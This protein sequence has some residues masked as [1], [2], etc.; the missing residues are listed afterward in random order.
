[1]AFTAT[2][3]VRTTAALA[4]GLVLG[5]TAH[6]QDT[7]PSKPIKIVVPFPPGQQSDDMARVIAA[8]LK[9]AMGQPVIVEN[10][11]GQAGSIG[12]AQFA[13][14][15]P[16]GYTLLL[17]ATA[18]FSSNKFLYRNVPYDPLK[19]F[20]P[21]TMLSTTPLV[22]VVG[23][24]VP[25]KSFEE[26]VKI[27]KEDPQ[28]LTYGSSG[29]GTISHTSMEAFKLAVGGGARHIPYQG[30]AA[31]VLALRA[32]QIDM[33][34]EGVFVVGKHIESGTMRALAVPMPQRN[35]MF[36]DIPTLAEAGYPGFDRTAWVAMFAPAHTPRPI[37]DRLNAEIVKIMRKPEIIRKYDTLN[38]GTTT[39]E[40]AAAWMVKDYGYWRDVIQRAHITAE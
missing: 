37:V 8:E 33:M 24:H 25:V 20:Q 15:A 38:I 23:K 17:G 21:I 3:L 1:M 11:P 5:L 14:A 27:M 7:Y 36:P 22:L 13:K 2:T 12:V 31:S 16:D 26:L 9:N 28:R 40:D 34:I 29:V 39:P 6:A 30:N 18:A 32:G 19:D 10:K 35:P 4:L